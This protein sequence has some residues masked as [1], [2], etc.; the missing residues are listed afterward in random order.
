MFL[1]PKSI[2]NWVLTRGRVFGGP[3]LNTNYVRSS[4]PINQL[5]NNRP[6]P[7]L[8]HKIRRL[9]VEN[10]FDLFYKLPLL[11]SSYLNAI[12]GF[13]VNEHFLSFCFCC[14][15]RTKNVRKLREKR[16]LTS[17]ESGRKRI[18]YLEVFSQNPNLNPTNQPDPGQAGRPTS[19]MSFA[20]E[21]SWREK[22]DLFFLFS[23]SP[24]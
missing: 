18:F 1:I 2:T 22:K 8:N 15:S 21:D 20:A 16:R 9:F 19:L 14:A 17:H 5:M 11:F 4:W 12:V 3:Q 13:V 24:D 7:R 6:P 10:L 23:H